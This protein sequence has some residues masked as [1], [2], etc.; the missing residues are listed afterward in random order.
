M[1]E[2]ESSGAD[3]IM[4]SVPSINPFEKKMGLT[5]KRYVWLVAFFCFFVM[6]TANSN[7]L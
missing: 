5:S 4:I 1:Y 3:R 6:N 2:D 7:H